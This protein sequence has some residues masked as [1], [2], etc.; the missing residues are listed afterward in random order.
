M[1]K[2]IYVI[3]QICCKTSR[4]TNKNSNDSKILEYHL[5]PPTWLNSFLPHKSFI[6]C[7]TTTHHQL[8]IISAHPHLK[9]KCCG[10]LPY[11]PL[12][13]AAYSDWLVECSMKGEL[14][15]ALP[16]TLT[17]IDF[18]DIYWELS[19]LHHCDI[20]Y[21]IWLIVFFYQCFIENIFVCKLTG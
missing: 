6:Q 13:A 16:I 9:Y 20:T 2:T 7:P 17:A 14:F 1:S 5:Q 21:V 8:S 11:F 19:Y 10:S 15:E 4:I 18:Y 12:H 3:A